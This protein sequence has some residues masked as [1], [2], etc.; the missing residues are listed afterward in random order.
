[1]ARL[2]AEQQR[3]LWPRFVDALK[4]FRAHPFGWPLEDYLVVHPW[5]QG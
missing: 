2:L 5:M 4:R 1:M 3:G